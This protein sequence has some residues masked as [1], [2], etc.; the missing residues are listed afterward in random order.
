MKILETG[1]RPDIFFNLKDFFSPD[2]SARR[3]SCGIFRT[4]KFE[5][6]QRQTSFSDKRFTNI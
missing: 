3:T 6:G 2:G 4:S 1:E 5:P